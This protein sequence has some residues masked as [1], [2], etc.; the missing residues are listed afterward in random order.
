MKIMHYFIFERVWAGK[1]YKVPAYTLRSRF[2]F[3]ITT[4]FVS[5][6]LAILLYANYN[7]GL[8]QRNLLVKRNQFFPRSKLKYL[9]YNTTRR[10]KFELFLLGK[11]AEEQESIFIGK[12]NRMDQKRKKGKS[13]TRG[14]LVH[15]MR[16][17]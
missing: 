10:W 11:E 14:G 3:N 15:A 13:G 16:A 8:L 6:F 1:R 4:L 9:L 12:N 5:T 2:S 17:L 7:L